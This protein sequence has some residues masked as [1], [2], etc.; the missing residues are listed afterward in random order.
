MFS[1]DSNCRNLVTCGNCIGYAYETCVWCPA[2]DHKGHRCQ[3]ISVHKENNSWCNEN[4]YNPV[5]KS[6]ILQ[7]DTF[8]SGENGGKVVQYMPQKM[9]ILVRPGT[10]VTFKM[11]YKSAQDYPLDVYYLMDYSYTMRNHKKQLE[12]QGLEIYRQ[13]TKLTNN[14]QLGIGSFVEKPALPFA[15]PYNNAYSFEN[16]LS[17]TKNMTL[18][19]NVLT[20]NL[21]GSNYDNPEAGLDAL[22]QAMVCQKQIG[23]RES[24]RRI[25][26][27]TTDSTYHSAGDGKFVGAVKPNDMKC[28]LEDNKYTMSLVLD[29]PSVSQV[30]KVAT[31]NNFKI[32]FAAIHDVKI[33][34]EGLAKKIRGAKYVEL[35]EASNLITMIK[36]EYLELIR[37]ID[38]MT[39]VPPHIELLLEPD[40]RIS[41]NCIVKHNESIN[42]NTTLKVKSCPKSKT[43]SVVKLGPVALNEKL[44]I[45]VISDCECDCERNILKTALNSTK[46]SGNGT[47]QCGICKCNENRY[48]DDCR[49][50]GSSTISV[51]LDKCKI[52]SNDTNYCS[53]RGTCSCGKCV[54]C[55]KGF[56]GDYCQYD[57]TACP[58]PGGKLCAD[59][60]ICRYG[61]C[62]CDS[63]STGVGC[64]CPIDNHS[65]F[66]PHSKEIC[67]GN[68]KCEC[69]ECVCL[70]M[71]SS[72]RTCSGRFCDSCDEFAKKRCLEL[73]IYA[74]CNYLYNKIYCD[75]LYNQTSLTEVKMVT[76][77]DNTLPDHQMAK[78]CK[79]QFGN[80]TALV[81]KYLYPLSSPNILHVI[82]QKELEQ[83]PEV[84]LFI[85]IGVPF[86]VLILI[87]LLTI[88]IWKILVDIHDAREYKSFAE[89]SAA[90]G[91]TVPGIV[92]PVYRAPTVNINNPTFNRQ[93]Q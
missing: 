21:T 90:A 60:G 81:F 69:G 80:G 12:T 38:I 57:D 66:A 82:I 50:E 34:Y 83:P 7:N 73:E 43:P 45:S 16:H 53:G 33:I 47:Y 86:G 75:E 79:K 93:S 46:C 28:H 58:S 77:L 64:D 8:N 29:Y 85:A 56:S 62:E 19:K 87:G 52:N 14:V 89:K 23:W 68:G 10:P 27:L 24:A 11:S 39:E 13:L 30:N 18:F 17:L 20:G 92:N 61:K 63:K 37:S 1:C 36:N 25:I 41:G 88:M 59:R 32:I 31:E 9:D 42:I 48:G 55:Y 22:M 84:N 2:G 40:C 91:F 72:N 67:S 54:L 35:K 44:L 78:W 6:N 51:D 15:G 4:V 65:C 26:V 74:E 71:E 76:K 49:C 70:P 3:S 5:F